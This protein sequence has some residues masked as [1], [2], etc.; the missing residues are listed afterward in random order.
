MSSIT[1]PWL[2]T[3]QRSYQQIKSKLIEGLSN[4][5]DDNG[6]QLITD[7][8]DG[9]ILIIVISMFAAIAEVLHFYIDNAGRE[10]FLSTA[11]KYS[12]VLKHGQLVDYHARAAIAATVDVTLVRPLN[13]SSKGKVISIPQ[14][15]E[16]KDK[17]GN[18]WLSAR[19]V[20]WNTNVSTCKVPLIQHTYYEFENLYGTQIPEGDQVQ[21]SLGTLTEGLYEE[22]TMSLEIGS[23]TWVLVK[24]F[25]Y[26][27][28]TDKHF[29]IQNT[30]DDI[31]IIIFGNGIFGMKPK[32]GSIITVIS[33]YITNGS[34]GNIPAGN[35]Y[36]I[37]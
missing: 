36:N 18:T 24:T 14:G 16:F 29:I 11:R 22:G 28:P 7:T 33:C 6:K 20:T 12:S 31:P 15:T 5:K 32:A 25:A 37:H 35:K 27:K 4:I 26:S 13:S 17:A 2:G 21:I 3:Y 34:K 10:S 30:E 23:E 19:N 9:N 8:S 1:N